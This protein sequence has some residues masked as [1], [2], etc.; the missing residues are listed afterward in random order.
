MAVPNV[1][2]YEITML[3]VGRERT[4]AG[5]DSNY[6][7]AYPIY[8]SDMQRLSGGNS[9]G[10]GQNYPAVNQLNPVENRPDGENPLGMGEFSEYNQNVTRSAFNYIYDSSSS[11]NACLSGIP[12]PTP[13][14]HT[15]INNLVPDAVG[16]YYAY[17]TISGSTL[18]GTG[19]YSIY[20]TG[21]MPVASGK[22]MY[23]NSNGLITQIGNC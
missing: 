15:D 12:S 5:Y 2:N 8:M 1:A 17:T 6:N 21:N 3:K 11:S 20:S 23:V 18:A 7:L 10:S 13:Y 19:Y 14:F 16:I 22:W 9:S 4:G